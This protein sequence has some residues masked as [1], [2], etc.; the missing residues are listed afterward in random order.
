M[1]GISTT[2]NV[3]DH[4]TSTSKYAEEPK[5][6]ELG[7]AE[8]LN[9]LMVKM[10]NQDPL[11]PQDDTAFI[12]ELA[13]FSELEEIEKLNKNFSGFSASM[14]SNQAL[15]ASSLVGR[16]V[17]VPGDESY[18][19]MNDVISGSVT[20]PA[21]TTDLQVDIYGENGSLLES[22]P[23]G[24]QTRG[25]VVFRWD[26]KFMEV[27]GELLD[28]QS[29]EENGRAPGKYRFE[30]TASID[31]EPTRIETALSANVN[32]V[33]LGADGKLTLNLAG[34]GPVAMSD[35]KQFN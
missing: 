28:W 2:G 3:L 18:L 13:Q 34:I 11:N 33:T 30:V 25:D 4:L 6:N 8:F 23:L 12:A 20:L 22:V 21:T 31:G 29:G 19:A 27:N 32:S 1:T 7:R 5:T 15:Q 16:K 26:G 10:Q 24:L 9:L 35:V 14:M 17:T